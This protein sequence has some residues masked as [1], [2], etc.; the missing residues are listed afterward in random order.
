MRIKG[1]V[2]VLGV[3][4]LFSCKEEKKQVVDEIVVDKFESNWESL[5]KNNKE[6]DWF[7]DAKLGI[8]FHWGIYSVPAF[9]SEWY[10]RWM[11][12]ENRDKWGK[13]TFQYHKEHFGDPSVF[14]YHDFIPM[15][16]AEKFDAKEWAEL[17]KSAGAKFAGPV[18]QHHDGFAMWASK[19]NPWNV[20]DMGPKK[21]ILGDLYKELKK[22]DLKTIA[23]FHHARTLQRYTKDTANWGGTASH[24]P[25]NPKYATSST[26]PKLKYLYGN[27]EEDEFNQ[28][29]LDEVEEVVDNYQPD[30]IWF[31]S[32][33]DQIPESYLQKMVAHQF[34]SGVKNNKENLVAYKQKDL[35]RN[36][37]VLDIEQGGMKEMSPDYWLTDIT[38]SDGSWCFT[39]GLKYK[40]APLLIKNMIDVWSKKGIVLLNV[41]PRADGVI[42]DEQRA[43]LA[44]IGK[45][46]KANAEAIYGTRTHDVYGYGEA[47]IKEGHFGGQSATVKYNESDIRFTTSKDKKA[48]YVFCLGMP[49]E[50]SVIKIQHVFSENANQKIK[51]V[52]IVGNNTKIKRNFKDG[53]LELTTPNANLMNDIATVFKVEF[54]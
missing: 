38:I 11:Y 28:Y 53:L 47:E 5:A 8:Y 24:Y 27:L 19:V 29:W 7:A 34:N 40:S 2:I 16:K 50:N 9:S 1:I 41:S 43:I 39:N 44:E 52:S 37:G 33:L 49:K 18:A 21:D 31:D 25:Y 48:L 35:P 23:T 14:N 4:M 26:D 32:W 51:N 22:R 20:K 36:V 45:W 3:L 15:F 30:I 17:F 10:P 12:V 46:T 42:P 54:E 13:G 6:P